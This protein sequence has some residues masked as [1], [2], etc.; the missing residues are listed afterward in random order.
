[1][2]PGVVPKTGEADKPSDVVLRADQ[3]EPSI[4]RQD[5]KGE[6]KG[7]HTAPINKGTSF[8]IEEQTRGRVGAS[9]KLRDCVLKDRSLGPVKFPVNYQQGDASKSGL[10]ESHACLSA[11]ATQLRPFSVTVNPANMKYFPSG[12]S[13]FAPR[14]S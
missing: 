2:K 10:G 7:T 3:D 8:Q 13:V 4:W 14:C 12:S 6:D 11:S 1:L 9:N 5:I